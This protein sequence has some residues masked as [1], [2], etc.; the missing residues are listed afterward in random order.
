MEDDK[1]FSKNFTKILANSRIGDRQNEMLYDFLA[2]SSSKT[3]RWGNC[4][5]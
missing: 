3:K 2:E 1:A 5:R 4:S